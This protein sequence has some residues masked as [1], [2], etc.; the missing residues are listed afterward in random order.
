MQRHISG[1][2]EEELERLKTD[3]VALGGTVEHQVA[4]ATRAFIQNDSELAESV[5]TMELQVNR[6][7]VEL[8]RL[9]EGTL[10]LRQPAASDFRMIVGIFK[11]STDLERIGDEA[12]RIAKFV[13]QTW[14]YSV[15]REYHNIMTELIEQA[16]NAVR[17][18]LDAFTRL[19]VEQA[20]ETIVRDGEIDRLYDEVVASSTSQIVENSANLKND[21]AALWVARSLERIGDHAKNISE[22][23]IYLVEGE[24]VVH[25]IAN[26]IEPDTDHE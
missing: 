18:A 16:V 25:N 12:D 7:T 17:N 9:A 14:S 6:R 1:T 4:D 24:I 8:N 22:T 3:F 23:V 13:C 2:F 21:L 20:K 19:N 11:T 26:A 5:K 15:D 10:A